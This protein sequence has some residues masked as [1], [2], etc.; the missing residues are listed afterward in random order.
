MSRF[1]SHFHV[2]VHLC[3]IILLSGQNWCFLDS[4]KILHEQYSYRIITFFCIES[5]MDV[6]CGV[7]ERLGDGK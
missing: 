2:G 6:T 5:E 7:Y 1:L 4:F 3:I